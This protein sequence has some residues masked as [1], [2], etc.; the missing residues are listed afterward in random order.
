MSH[1][2]YTYCTMSIGH[3]CVDNPILPRYTTSSVEGLGSL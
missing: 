2:Y 1:A 3:A